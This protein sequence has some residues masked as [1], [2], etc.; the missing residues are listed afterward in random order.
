MEL[1]RKHT[2]RVTCPCCF[3]PIPLQQRG[4]FLGFFAE[5]RAAPCPFCGEAIMWDRWGHGL[6]VGGGI[7]VGLLLIY[8]A[9]A[10]TPLL[11]RDMFHI[12]LLASTV[13]VVLGYMRLRLIPLGKRC[14]SGRKSEEPAKPQGPIHPE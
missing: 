1:F 10:S 4:R 8:G 7:A 11:S 2:A 5:R 14:A 6:F 3:T 12:L 9:V 13:G